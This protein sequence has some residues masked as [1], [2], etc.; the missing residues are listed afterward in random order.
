MPN[1]ALIVA[2]RTE[3]PHMLR[4]AAG[5]YRFGHN[6]VGLAVSGVGLKRARYAAQQ[7]CSGSLGFQPDL[8]IH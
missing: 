3:V 1:I 5:P 4:K 2:M 7:V 8:L 6:A